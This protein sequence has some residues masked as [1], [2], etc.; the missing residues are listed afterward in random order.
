MELL[1]ATM[2]WIVAPV[3]AFVWLIYQRQ[4]DHHTDIQVIKS[5]MVTNKE[6]ADRDRSEMR[7]ITGI[8]LKK[9]DDIESYLRTNK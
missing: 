6:S 7:E 4:Q 1:D 8:I 2:K 5:Q 3:A 9:L